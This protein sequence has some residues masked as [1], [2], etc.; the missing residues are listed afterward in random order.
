MVVGG[1]EAT[2][3]T[4]RGQELRCSSEHRDSRSGNCVTQ[5]MLRV[6][7]TKHCAAFFQSR[8]LQMKAR[9]VTRRTRS[10]SKQQKHTRAT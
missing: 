3:N 5:R 6:P 7:Q 1:E 10:T 8:Q 9:H 2:A 4:W